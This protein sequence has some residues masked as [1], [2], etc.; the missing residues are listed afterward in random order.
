M[1]IIVHRGSHQIGGC[2]TEIRT[3]SAR[4]AVDFGAELEGAESTLRIDGL[5][6]GKSSFGGVFLTHYHDDHLGL[7]EEINTD[8]PIYMSETALEIFRLYSA[9][10]GKSGAAASIIPMSPLVPVTLGDITVTPLPADHSA[11]DANMFLIE[12]QGKKVL[13]TGDFRLHGFRGKATPKILK[14]YAASLDALIIE[15]TQLGR[16][17]VN[18]LTER[19]LQQKLQQIIAENP[20][21]FMLCASTNIDRL[22]A[23]YNAVPTGRY[24]VCDKYQKAILDLVAKRTDSEWY[25]FGKALTYGENLRLAQRGFVMPVRCGEAFSKITQEFPESVLVYSMWG[26]YLDGRNPKLSEFVLPFQKSN[27]MILL[28]SSGHADPDELVEICNITQPKLV[29]PIHTEKASAL[30]VPHLRMVC[31]GEIITV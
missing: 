21:I 26:G 24:F 11:Y 15:G 6:S 13:H 17:R 20:Q 16:D 3:N 9:R 14:K 23:L 1:Q 4:I 19:Q 22:A 29:L 18:S 2:V 7:I 30:D 31:D 10:V 28:H 27:R 25:K 12:A 5:N 8:V